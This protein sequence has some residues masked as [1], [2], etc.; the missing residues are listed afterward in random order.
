MKSNTTRALRRKLNVHKARL[1]GLT[2]AGVT[3]GAL[4]LSGCAEELTQGDMSADELCVTG[5]CDNVSDVI[6]DIYSDM[7]RVDLG[8]LVQ[9]GAGLATDELNQALSSA[10]YLSLKL[11]ETSLFGLERRLIFGQVTTEDINELQAGLTER[12]GEDAFTAQ[13]NRLRVETLRRTP[14]SVFAETHFKVGV[15]VDH[16]WTLDHG[17]RVGQVGFNVSPSIEA[18]VI[19]PYDSDIE[20]FYQSP[21]AALKA[22]KGFV[23]PRSIDELVKMAPGSSVT[24]SGDGGVGVNIGVGV[25][26]ITGLMTDYLT[27][28]S[29]ISAGARSALTGKVDIQLIR[30]ENGDAFIDVGLSRQQV[31]HFELALESGYGVEGLPSLELDVAGLKVN[32]ADVLARALER[33][34]NKT[35]APLDGRASDSKSEGRLSVARFQFDLARRSVELDQAISQTMRGDLRL[36]QALANRPGSG[37]SQHFE[38]NKEYQRES[39]YLGFRF[40]SMRFFKEESVNKG[41][42]HISENGQNQELLFSEMESNSGWFFTDRGAK[43]RQLTSIRRVNNQAVEA[44]NNARLILRERDRFLTKD[45]ILDHIDPLLAYFFGADPVFYQISAYTDVLSEYVDNVCGNR[46]DPD[47]SYSERQA[48]ERC[49]SEIADRPMVGDLIDNAYAAAGELSP[50][51]DSDFDPTFEPAN[52]I[53]RQLL[54][55]KIGISGIHDT[56]NVGLNGPRGALISQVRFSNSAIDVLLSDEAP[57]RFG[58]ELALILKMMRSDR[59]DETLE[60]NEDAEKFV[61]SRIDE[62]EP[63]VEVY[64]QFVERFGQYDYIGS[65]EL[66]GQGAIGDASNLLIIPKDQQGKARV[67]SI[68]ALKGEIIGE[69]FTA[70]TE[71]ARGLREPDQFLIGYALLSLVSPQDIEFLVNFKFEADHEGGYNRYDTALYSR[72][73]TPLINAGQFSVDDLVGA[74]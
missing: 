36:A 31:R 27:I 57:K 1:V 67:S 22:T 18:I 11:S 45:Q 35:L 48:F 5:K 26:L 56:P 47:E 54:D 53:A 71:A 41:V 74:E 30:G 23:L 49:V 8:D 32:L 16:A 55:L 39:D 19:A 24:L 2:L 44:Q 70:L 12:F 43:W 58:E 10:D 69:L 64:S 62:I 7:R 9:I 38:M 52:V 14:G 60:K 6:D 63:M 33:Q 51:W 50:N 66:P 40:L 68:A 65:L 25:P 29:R 21:L 46:P 17:D 15:G 37:V 20:A 4:W 42:V 34:L 72:G 3:A 61:R 28:S 59:D 73:A 13:I